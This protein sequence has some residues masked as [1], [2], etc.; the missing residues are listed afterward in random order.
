LQICKFA[1]IEDANYKI[2]E[3]RLE[4]IIDSISIPLPIPGET[5]L[6][7]RMKKLSAP[8]ATPQ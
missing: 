6:A 4:A 5:E 3:R 7:D 2:V 8:T 1:S